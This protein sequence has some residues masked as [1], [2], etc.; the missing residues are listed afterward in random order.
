MYV[1]VKTELTW[2]GE[3]FITDDTNASSILCHAARNNIKLIKYY[4]VYLLCNK[5]I[6]FHASQLVLSTTILK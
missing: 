1:N 2:L 5:Q 6:S 4:T 3:D